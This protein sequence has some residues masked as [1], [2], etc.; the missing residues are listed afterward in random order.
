MNRKLGYEVSRN[1]AL[2]TMPITRRQGGIDDVFERDMIG[3]HVMLLMVMQKDHCQYLM[4]NTTSELVLSNLK[5]HI[6]FVAL[7]LLC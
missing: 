6:A 2:T 3:A 7:G 5:K 4:N 1:V